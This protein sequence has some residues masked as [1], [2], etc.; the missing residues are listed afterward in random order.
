MF[1]APLIDRYT[2]REEKMF[3]WLRDSAN[4]DVSGNANDLSMIALLVS[5]IVLAAVAV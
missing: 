2:L 5:A 3:Q 4:F 1:P